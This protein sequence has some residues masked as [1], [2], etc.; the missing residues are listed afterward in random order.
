M[1]QSLAMN[2]LHLV[3]STKGRK[4][5][6]KR[7]IRDDLCAYQAGIFNQWDSPASIVGAA[8]DHVHCLFA[9]SKNYALKK[10]VEEVKKGSS[11][12]FKSVGL[13]FHDFQWQTGYA[14]FS[15]SESNLE[16]VSKYIRN[17]DV[18]H[19][20]RTFQEELRLLLQRHKIEFDE[21]HVWN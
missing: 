5:W 20:R 16:A 12:W 6:I 7:E 4:T 10:I 15:V 8:E 9:L 1:S 17:Q 18:H 11:K 3:Y 14:A 19:A 2:W 13:P 21:K